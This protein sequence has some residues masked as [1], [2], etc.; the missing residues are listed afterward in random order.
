M[1]KK[2]SKDVRKENNFSF[3]KI[4]TSSTIKENRQG[5]NCHVLYLQVKYISIFL[6]IYVS[7]EFLKLLKFFLYSFSSRSAP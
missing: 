5:K 1:N 6:S 3:H 2:T 4:K 7:L